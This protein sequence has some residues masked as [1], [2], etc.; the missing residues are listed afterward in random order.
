MKTLIAVA[1]VLTLSACALPQTTVRTGA[2]QPGLIVQ[3][4]S[5]GAVLYV[6]GLSMGPAEQY[7]GKPKVLAVLAG[8]HTLEIH[9]G[10]TVIF[11]DKA[12]FTNGETHP[13]RLLP[14]AAP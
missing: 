13:I 9:Q 7:D 2:T 1:L 8:V 6:D 3:G 10:S 5:S 4:A 12:L 14:S 11:H